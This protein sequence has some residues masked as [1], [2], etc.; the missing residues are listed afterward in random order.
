MP[1]YNGWEAGYPQPEMVPGPVRTI[2]TSI[3]GGWNDTGSGY[4]QDSDTPILGNDTGSEAGGAG[5]FGSLRMFFSG[6]SSQF[7]A[8]DTAA[9]DMLKSTKGTVELWFKTDTYPGSN[10]I[11]WESQRWPGS[12]GRGCGRGR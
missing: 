1:N 7:T 5:L 11:F 3:T 6:S 8:T 10:G 12:A 2:T 9:G 4:A